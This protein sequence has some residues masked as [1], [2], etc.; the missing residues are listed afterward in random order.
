MLCVTVILGAVFADA[1]ARAQT[2][3]ATVPAFQVSADDVEAA[4]AKA[5]VAKGAAERVQATFTHGQGPVFTAAQPLTVDIKTLDYDKRT[6]RWTGNLL[7]T[8]GAQVLSAMPA[9]GRFQEMVEVPVLKRQL[10]SGETI[11]EADIDLMQF[12]MT[13]TRGDTVTDAAKL[14]GLS[15]RVVISPARPIRISEI[16]APSILKKNALITLEYNSGGMYIRTAG[17]VLDNGAKGDVINVR[18]VNSKQIVRAVVADAQTA[19]VAPLTE[20]SQIPELTHVN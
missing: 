5:L 4:V 7:F 14:V 2:P 9:S 6:G 18:N 11:A 12:P 16:T 8:A 20:T 19:Q 3:A 13:R 10:R 1:T 17:Q 15:P